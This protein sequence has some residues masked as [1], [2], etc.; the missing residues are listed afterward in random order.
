PSFRILATENRHESIMRSVRLLGLGTDAI[1]YARADDAGRMDTRSLQE[2]L[3]RTDKDPVIVCLQAGDLNTGVFDRFQDICPIAHAAKAWVQMGGALGLCVAT[4]ER[5][6]H[7]LRG[8][9]LADSWAT[10]G[11]KWLNLPF[12]CGIAFVADPAAHRA[13]FVQDTSYAIPKEGVRN[14]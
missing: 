9:E 5:Y 10:D 4:S 2:I 12:D 14:Q 8:A 7:L 11:H 1:E 6:R 3:R 13:P